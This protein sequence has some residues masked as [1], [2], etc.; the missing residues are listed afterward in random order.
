MWEV[1]W[2]LSLFQKKTSSAKNAFV[3]K[4]Y[5]FAVLLTG[6][7]SLIY[8]IALSLYLC[9]DWLSMACAA[10]SRSASVSLLGNQKGSERF[11]LIPREEDPFW[12]CIHQFLYPLCPIYLPCKCQTV[13]CV[14]TLLFAALIKCILLSSAF[15]KWFDQ[16]ILI[17]VTSRP[18]MEREKNLRVEAS[19]Y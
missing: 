15:I 4:K 14:T 9:F 10:S 6:L 13:L 11:L 16:W 12:I 18:F 3:D 1:F 8:Q 5:K 7:V 17:T 19:H 2:I